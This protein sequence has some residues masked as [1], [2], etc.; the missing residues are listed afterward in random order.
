MTTHCPT[1]KRASGALNANPHCTSKTC[2]W[3]KCNCGT[4]YDR[5]TG[6]WFT[7]AK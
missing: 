2:T 1:C 3:N 5:T 7:D 6:K 4:T